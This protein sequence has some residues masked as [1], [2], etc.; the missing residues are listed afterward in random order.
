M[1][2]DLNGVQ[3]KIN[4]FI[5]PTKFDLILGR[6]WLKQA[7]PS[8]DWENDTW[9][10]NN[11]RV[12]LQPCTNIKKN[13]HT[14]IPKLSYLISHKQAD[15]LIKKGGESFLFFIKSNDEDDKYKNPKLQTSDYWDNLMHE[16]ADVFKDEL[17]GIPPDRGIHHLIDTGD[18]KP[19]SRPPYKMS[20]LE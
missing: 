20:P 15:R 13:S 12:K 9:Y 16:F 11:G 4:A 5:F 10:L 2:I 18:A 3:E 19:V 8:P 6:S 17:P 7:Q 14:S 1:D